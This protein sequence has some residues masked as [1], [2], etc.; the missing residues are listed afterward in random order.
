MLEPMHF[1]SETGK[2]YASAIEQMQSLYLLSFLLTADHNKAEQCLFS[3]IGEGPEGIGV[4]VDWTRLWAR[5]AVIK[6]AI[7]L[8]VPAPEHADDVSRVSL[9]EPARWTDKIPFAAILLLDAFERF[10]FVMSILEGQSDEECAILLRC[11][12]RDVMMARAWLSGVSQAQMSGALSKSCVGC[13]NAW[14]SNA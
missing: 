11:S 12:R 8:I 4:F 10:V 3:T 7:D 14:R 6:K 1:V 2:S 13:A 9:T 5:R